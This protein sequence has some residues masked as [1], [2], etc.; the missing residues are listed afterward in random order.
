MTLWRLYVCETLLERLPQHLQPMACAC[1]PLVE[2][3][4]AVMRQ[5]HLAGHGHLAAADHADVGDSVVWGA[6]RV[7]GVIT[8]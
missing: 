8:V 7:Q 5:R 3:Q 1:G 2:A 6:T 4:P